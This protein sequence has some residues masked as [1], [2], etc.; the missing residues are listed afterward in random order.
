MIGLCDCNNFFVSCQRL[1]DPSLVGR[2]VVVLSGNDGCIIARSNEAKA[3]GIKMGQPRFEVDRVLKQHNVVLISSNL[4]L[5][6]DISKRVMETLKMNAPEVEVYS[7]D[8][9][10]LNLEG[11]ELEELGEYGR[12]LSRLVGRNTGIPV[13]IGISHNKTLSKI[14]SKLAKQYPRLKGCC[15]MHRDEDIAKVLSTYPIED[16]W[17]IGRRYASML[18]NFGVKTAEQFRRLDPEWVQSKM[19]VVGLRT[20]R[21][22]LGES[23]LDFEVQHSTR[24]SIMVSRTFA[25]ELYELEELH[26]VLSG[27]LSRAAEKLRAQGSKAREL[28]VFLR[29]NRFREDI[30]QQ[31]EGRIFKFLVPTSSTLEMASEMNRM[32]EELYI[33][34]NGYKRAGVLLKGITSSAQAQQ[35]SLFVNNEKS[36]RHSALME[37]VDK[38][39]RATGGGSSNAGMNGS[40]GVVRLASEGF[41]G[42]RR[43]SDYISPCY[44]TRWSDILTI[45]V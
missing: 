2:P 35:T 1:F 12:S 6:T 11:M 43:N 18:H 29:T 8:E 19:S 20:Q 7:V 4:E 27:Y 21:E 13:S 10:F 45:K 23:C 22:L 32:L 16:V 5:Y 37:A 34:G 28:E 25:T 24:Q 3:L 41:G 44:S 15:L 36:M 40:G 31:N 39:N 33:L 42:S 26:Q 17:G 9:A 30:I 38:I 14:A